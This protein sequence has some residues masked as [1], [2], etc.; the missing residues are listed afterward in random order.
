MA[1]YRYGFKQIRPIESSSSQERLMPDGILLLKKARSLGVEY[2]AVI[3]EILSCQSKKQ[4]RTRG[5]Y[6]RYLDEDRAKIRKYALENG[7]K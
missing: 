1:L 7:N 3:S 6:L 5:K 4:R 2:E